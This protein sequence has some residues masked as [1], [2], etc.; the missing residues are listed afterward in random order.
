MERHMK[1]ILVNELNLSTVQANCCACVMAL[2]FFDGIHK[3]HQRVIEQAKELAKMKG[4]PLA[5]MSFFPHPKTVF[6]NQ[7]IDYLMPMEEKARQLK[8][9]GVDIFYIVEF[10]KSFAALTPE[11]FVE[12]Y[13]INLQ[14]RH[15]VAGFDYT[16]G[17]K[18]GGNVHTISTHSLNEITVD[19][20]D[21]YTMYG[22]KVSSTYLRELLRNGQV[23]TMTALLGRSYQV[24]YHLQH[25]VA[26]HY[27][28]PE[29]GYYYVTVLVGQ[30]AISQVVN[31]CNRAKIQFNHE[32]HFE[33]CTIIF[34]QR[35]TQYSQVIS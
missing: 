16:Y 23:E 15:A 2:G 18:G 17:A 25:G 29:D 14:V 35:V 12:E 11:T 13:L 9:L 3:G 5:V 20:V 31:V 34:H 28:L 19:V 26:Q 8:K 6:S 22:S 1:V 33:E 32:L 30:R 24:R 27:T 21:E 7:E 4:L 10:T